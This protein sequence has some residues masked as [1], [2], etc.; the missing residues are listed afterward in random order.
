MKSLN[1]ATTNPALRGWIGKPGVLV[2]PHVA[3][4]EPG[5]ERNPAL[6]KHVS[7]K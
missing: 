7:G 6:T 5:A 3:K 2:A 1:S 4:M